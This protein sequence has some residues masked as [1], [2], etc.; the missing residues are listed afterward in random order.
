MAAKLIA[1]KPAY[2]RVLIPWERLQPSAGRKP[3][4]D[5]PFGGC[6]RLVPLCRSEHGMRGLLSAIKARQA[7]DGGWRIL[8]VPYFTPLWAMA[9]RR[10]AARRRATATPARRC[11][12][13]PP[14]GGCCARSTAWPTRSA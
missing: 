1:L 4:W 2:V 10:A 5:A 11:R 13:S 12:G 8:A 14:T 3:N 6:P 7:Q 9:G